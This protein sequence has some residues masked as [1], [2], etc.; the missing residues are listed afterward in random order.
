MK[1]GKSIISLTL[2]VMILAGFALP[3]SA[4]EATVT[5]APY[6]YY[7]KTE[8]LSEEGTLLA[9]CTRAESNYTAGSNITS[10]A[11]STDPVN[12]RAQHLR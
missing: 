6:V 12:P 9:G 5:A 4:S 10:E 2:A 7:S 11:G 8:I 1:T 3:A